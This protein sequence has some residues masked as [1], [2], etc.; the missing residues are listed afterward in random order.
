MYTSALVND[1]TRYSARIL[2]KVCRFGTGEV[3]YAP[4]TTVISTAEVSKEA[5]MVVRNAMKNV[6]ENGSAS[7]IFEDYP[8]TIGGKTGTA[9]VS[10]T[11]S[12]NAI[13]TAF[14]PF[15]DPELVV[16]CVIEQGNTGSN[17]GVAV[18]G[19]FDYYF[20]VGEEA[21]EAPETPENV[22]DGGTENAE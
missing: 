6:I 15:D 5:C 3:V 20:E 1:G 17:A 22:N 7:E 4:E 2:Y 18:K 12:D 16:T 9:Q 14:A 10:K 21:P 19:L 13:F 11:K 8:I